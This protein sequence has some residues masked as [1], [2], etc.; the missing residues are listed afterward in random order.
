MRAR[1][2]KAGIR[3][4]DLQEQFIHARGDGGQ[5]VNKVATCVVLEHGPSGIRVRCE[6]ARTQA[7]N[8]VQ[9]RVRL[10]EKLEEAALRRARQKKQAAEKKKRQKRRP[11][12]AARA[13]NVDDKR[14]RGETKKGRGKV[15]D[16]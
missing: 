3:E 4:E 9:A 5:N 11:S 16:Y 8:R 1:L 14:K 10:A 6:Q 7:A 13:R 2:R 15:R 12:K